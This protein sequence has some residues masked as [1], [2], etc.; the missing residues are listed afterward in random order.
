MKPEIIAHRG[1]SA[2]VP[3][4]TLAALEAAIRAGAGAV[5]FDVQ[6]AACGTPVLFHDAMLGRTT[7]GVG[8]L[9]RRP[10]GHLKALDAGAWFGSRFAGEAI[11][12][13]VEALAH[14]KG[15][16]RRVYQDVKGYREME[17][18]DRMAAV[19][20]YAGMAEFSTFVSSDWI[21]LDRLKG[22]APEIPRGYTVE[23][24]ATFPEAMDRALADPGSL[25]SV[26]I[27]VALAHPERIRSATEAGIEIMT[28]TVDD[29]QQAEQARQAGISRI[30]CN[31]VERILAWRNGLA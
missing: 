21:I 18:L 2:R 28:W 4:N 26:E 6:P 25:L 22:V 23:S 19:T 1:Y 12:T 30:M 13:Q 5:E 14:L 9:R 20:R 31:E 24:V 17:D 10:L 15:R 16:V 27:D 7:N 11:P 8:P 3:E 29:P